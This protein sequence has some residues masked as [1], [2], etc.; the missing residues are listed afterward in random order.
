MSYSNR[1]YMY[2]PVGLLL[3][4]AILYS[5]F[6]RVEADTM[7]AR[8]DR[9]NGGEIAPGISFSFAQKTVGGF[10]FRLDVLLTGVR[11]GYRN[12]STAVDWRT[13]RF[14]LHRMAYGRNQ[15]IFESDG[16]QT[17]SWTTQPNA[18]PVTIML[19][20]ETARASAILN[21]GRLLRFDLDL[22]RPRGTGAGSSLSPTAFAADRA[23]FHALARRNNT[24]DVALQV[25]NGKAGSPP[26]QASL[27]LIDC[28]ITLNQADVLTRLEQGNDDMTRAFELW[29]ARMGVADVT[30]LALN[31]PDAHAV[32]RGQL[33]LDDNDQISGTLRGD[34]T[35]D[36]G[37]TQPVQLDFRNGSVAFELASATAPAGAR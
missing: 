33:K 19:S 13:D 7:S 1:I 29:R 4:L 37:G 18:M 24:L 32:L 31:W 30:S 2:G 15:F 22:W 34:R 11:L 16:T 12:G 5:V 6:W 28:R 17:I 23:Q 14:A 21:Q 9:A 20:P 36:H 26:A 10:P 8:L 25:D 3:L 35:A 27:P